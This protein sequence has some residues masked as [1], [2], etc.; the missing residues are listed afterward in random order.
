MPDKDTLGLSA[1]LW[2][3]RGRAPSW[4]GLS[5]RWGGG[6]EG[7]TTTSRTLALG[8]SRGKGR[9]AGAPLRVFER[10]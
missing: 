4:T 9:I 3:P 6:V 5:G 8:G 7:Q 10:C 1:V 2:E